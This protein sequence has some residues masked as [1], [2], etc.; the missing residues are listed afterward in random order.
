M[1]YALVIA[2]MLCAADAAEAPDAAFDQF[3]AD[4]KAK[5]DGIESL[6]AKFTQKT[7]VPDETLDT[8][9]VIFYAKPRRILLRTEEPE[10]T[11]M[12]DGRVIFEYEPEIKQ[13][14]IYDLG[15]NPRADVFFLG[16]DDD[17]ESLRRNYAVSLFTTP[18]EKEGKRGILLRPKN[19]GEEGFD[20]IEARLYL[21][22]KDYLPYRIHIQNDEDAEVVINVRGFRINVAPDSAQTQ[23]LAA[24]GT[25]VIK[26]DRVLKTVGPG[27]ERYPEALAQT[28]AVLPAPAA[29]VA[30]P[31]VTVIELDAPR[32]Q[33]APQP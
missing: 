19:P 5:R 11:T 25:K 33:E 29:P 1:I 16:F 24:E 26:D 13:L 4:F 18:D 27:G 6:D 3:F 17:T 8:D 12:V 7:I 14:V 32:A 31:S 21:R 20:F 10:R 28:E 30:G 23:I 22:D 9:G 2:A 15:E